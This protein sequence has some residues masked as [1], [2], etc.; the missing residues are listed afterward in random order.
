ML[1]ILIF[2]NWIEFA[3]N[4]TYNRFNV[5]QIKFNFIKKCYE[6]I[7]WKFVSIFVFDDCEFNCID[8]SLDSILSVIEINKYSSK[9]SVMKKLTCNSKMFYFHGRK[10]I[11]QKIVCE[12]D[13]KK[14]IQTSFSNCT[15]NFRAEMSFFSF[16]SP[17]SLL[18][19]CTVSFASHTSSDLDQKNLETNSNRSW[20]YTKSKTQ[21]K[22][23]SRSSSRDGDQ[24][25]VDFY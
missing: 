23:E 1:H 25:I 18:V 20:G 10:W 2:L 3:V 17:I 15:H 19:K 8:F 11:R 21:A 14:K 24:V 6:F 5:S 13:E 22:V 4:L 16:Y 9:G 7:K 12:K